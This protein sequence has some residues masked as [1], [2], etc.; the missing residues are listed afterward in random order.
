M[1]G[2]V[3]MIYYK[4]EKIKSDVLNFLQARPLF[5]MITKT[6]RSDLEVFDNP[7]DQL[8]SRDLLTAAKN[9][10]IIIEIDKTRDVAL[11]GEW[12]EKINAV[13][14]L[15]RFCNH[16]NPALAFEVFQFLS[17]MADQTRFRMPP[18]ILE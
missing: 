18:F 17:Q 14:S 13:L 16:T 2:L 15:N 12:D 6:Q 3:E 11:R 1:N 4:P 8:T 7:I 5:K 10:A 9:A